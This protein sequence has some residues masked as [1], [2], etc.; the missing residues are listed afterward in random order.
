MSTAAPVWAADITLSSDTVLTRE[1]YFVISL[2]SDTPPGT[3]AT[4]E[5]SASADFANPH[6]YIL[7]A[8]GNITITG[9]P[10][11]QYHFRARLGDG[12]FGDPL[13]VE[14]AHHSL[15]RAFSFFFIGL[16]L[17]VILVTTILL[18]NRSTKVADNAS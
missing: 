8:N 10:D 17:F 14:V 12:D 15:A 18:G 5:Q 7:P 16:V 1:G 9:L 13:V 6:V 2:A 3:T 11:G 4:L